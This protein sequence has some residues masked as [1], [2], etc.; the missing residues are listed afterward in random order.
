MVALHLKSSKTDQLEKGAS[1]YLTRS[2]NELCPGSAYIAVRGTDPGPLFRL[3]DGN[4]LLKSY[5]VGQVREVLLSLGYDQLNMPDIVSGLGRQGQQQQQQ[6]SQTL[7]SKQWWSS[8][9]FRTYI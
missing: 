1:V 2:N 7:T 9:A 5:I 3:A 6:V 4:S 8:S